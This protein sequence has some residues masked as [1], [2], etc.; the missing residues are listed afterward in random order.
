MSKNIRL[1]QLASNVRPEPVENKMR[2]WVLNGKNNDFYQYIIDMNDDSS[3]N[4]SVNKS[5]TDFIY[6]K[7]LRV[8]NAASHMEDVLK[9]KSVIHEREL[10]KIV[11]DFQV[12]GEAAM[13]VIKTKG[14]KLDSISHLPKQFVAPSIE[15]EDGEI[16]N[17]WFSRNWAKPSQAIPEAFSAFGTSSDAIEIYNLKPYT[18]GSQYFASCDYQSGLMYA[19]MERELASTNVN[20][21]KQGLSAGYIISIP[22]GA[23]LTDE[24]KDKLERKITQKLTGSSNAGSFIMSFQ[25][26]DQEP[27]TVTVFPTAENIHQQWDSLIETSIQKILTAHRCTSPS[28][29]GIISSSGFS[30][31]A[32]EMEQARLDLIKYVIAPK[33][34][35]ITDALEEIL[36]QYDIN[37]ELEFI[38]ITEK[39]ITPTA[40]D[41]SKQNEKEVIEMNHLLERYAEDAPEGFELHSKELVSMSAIQKSE[42]DTELWKIRYAYVGGTRKQQ[43]SPSRPF[44]LK[45]RA[46]EM[47]GKVFRKEDII[48]MGEE[49]VNGQFAHSGGKYSIWLYAGGVN[50]YH[51]WERRMFKK[52][53]QA[54]G[55]LYKGNPMQNVTETNVK[56]ARRQG[57]KI[58]KN[59]ADVAIA[60]ITKP[61]KG[62]YSG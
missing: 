12:F 38:P 54:D 59:A 29:V 8:K 28:I 21:I 48:A 40:T 26:R 47:S 1:L 60:E 41:L 61:N 58:P 33:Q 31:T 42:Q 23:S 17:Y 18:V 24:E 34:K 20:Y 5:Y 6:G 37:V 7:G 53:E 14:K 11:T 45:M 9:V 49:G 50:C 19:E 16:E 44:C 13:Q 32:E 2:N 56:E 36:T 57:A 10:K 52:K 22:D 55:E 35:M 25:A 15:N 39:V 3:T 46:L 43:K 4:G 62:K 51:R 27:I 30:N